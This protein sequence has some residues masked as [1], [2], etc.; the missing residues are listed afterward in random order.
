MEVGGSGDPPFG[1]LT[2]PFADV[3]VLLMTV[4]APDAINTE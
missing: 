1:G 2:N 4:V 3:K